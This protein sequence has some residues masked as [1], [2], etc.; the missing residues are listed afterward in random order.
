MK[1]RPSTTTTHTPMN[2]WSPEPA[3]TPSILSL[4]IA[5]VTALENRR[6]AIRPLSISIIANRLLPDHA[7]HDGLRYPTQWRDAMK[8]LCLIYQ[9]EETSA[10][11]AH[12]AVPMS[13]EYF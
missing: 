12:Q 3:R 5:V 4:A 13:Q 2:R 11:N 9:N 7:P 10:R 6:S 1:N 8:Y